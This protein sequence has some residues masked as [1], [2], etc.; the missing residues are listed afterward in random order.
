MIAAGGLSS[1]PIEFAARRNR[2]W[3]VSDFEA[4][5]VVLH[6]PFTVSVSS[7]TKPGRLLKQ[8]YVRFMLQLSTPMQNPSSGFR[9][10]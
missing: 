8:Y 9:R 6:N 10:I 4:G 3:L 5:D 2:K 1:N 7:P